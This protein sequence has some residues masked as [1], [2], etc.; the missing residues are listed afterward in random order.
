MGM[1]LLGLF[2]LLCQR[3]VFVVQGAPAPM[4][5]VLEVPLLFFKMVA[6]GT[7]SLGVAPCRCFHSFLS[8]RTPLLTPIHGY[9]RPL[10]PFFRRSR[11]P[12]GWT[13]MN[14]S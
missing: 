9:E 6:S 11:T 4:C 2:I 10:T 1:P 5:Q 13:P 14:T 12:P 7:P 8:S 3:F